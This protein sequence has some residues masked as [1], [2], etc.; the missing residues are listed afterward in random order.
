MSWNQEPEWV[1]VLFALHARPFPLRYLAYL[2]NPKKP[3]Q[4]NYL[5]GLVNSLPSSTVDDL[6]ALFQRVEAKCAESN[7]TD[8]SAETTQAFATYSAAK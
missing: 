3:N 4:K 6:Q 7:T 8:G 5:N 2:E 1:N